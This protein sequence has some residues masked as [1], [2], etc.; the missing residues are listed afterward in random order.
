[1][2]P[3]FVLFFLFLLIFAEGVAVGDSSAPHLLLKKEEG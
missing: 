2:S 1:M 3:L